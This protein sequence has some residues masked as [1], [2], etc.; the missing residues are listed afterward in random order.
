MFQRAELDNNETF[1]PVARYDT[2]RALI[3]IA[4]KAKF[5]PWPI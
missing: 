3:A 2:I 5:G 1:S 4:V